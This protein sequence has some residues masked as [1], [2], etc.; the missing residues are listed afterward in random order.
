M[1][2]SNNLNPRILYLD[3]LRGFALFGIL[4][5]NLPYL[6]E[7][8]YGFS[9]FNSQISNWARAIVSFFVVGKFFIIFSFLFGYGFGIQI[10]TKNSTKDSDQSSRRKF[11]RRLI[12]LLFFGI[13]HAAFLYDGDILVT[14]A[15][16]GFILY[17][18]RNISF[19]EWKL[20]VVLFWL[21]SLVCYFL[22][23]LLTYMDST[24]ETIL[25][26]LSQD[27]I[28]AH[29]ADFPTTAIQKIYELFY[30]FPYLVLYNWPSAFMMFLIGIWAHKNRIID[31]DLS[32]ILS[33][34]RMNRMRV[35]TIVIIAIVSNLCYTISYFLNHDFVYGAIFSSFLAFGGL[36]LSLLYCLGWKYFIE[37]AELNSEKNYTVNSLTLFLRKIRFGFINL[38]AGSG[39]MSLTN[40]LSQSFICNFIFN[41]WGLGF[42][43]QLPPEIYFFLSVPIYIFNLIFSNIWLRYFAQGPLEYVLRKWTKI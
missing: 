34:L 28:K 12:G 39:R 7:P 22:L 19:F 36:S 17:Q 3:F 25:Q 23:G 37:A 14:Y 31:K 15:I 18:F 1:H 6:A 9:E 35:Y 33:I 43:G 24:N 38:V 42:Y 40:Y 20:A 5:A 27:S 26:A 8:M 16:L 29:L 21:L 13:I 32:E 10:E 30:S 2:G 4:I 41:G 11:Y